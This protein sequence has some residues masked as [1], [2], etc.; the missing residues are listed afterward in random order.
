MREF[1]EGGL[2]MIRRI[3]CPT[4]LTAN[5]Q[6]PVGYALRLAKENGAELIVF[7]AT[8]FPVLSQYTC[9]LDACYPWESFVSMFKMD[10]LLADA[11]RRVRTFV[12]ARFGN[13]SAGVAWKPKVALG[14][15]AEEIVRAAYQEEVD[16][17]VMG[18]C[19]KGR[20]ARLFTGSIPEAVVRSVPCPVLSIDV[21]QF[22]YPSRGWRLPE[23]KGLL[24]NS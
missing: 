9:E 8:S 3:L 6:D 18:R 19:K 4:G 24:Q 15:A 17:V 7:H 1:F 13:E 10:Q 16:L 2:T 20:L 12:G 14:E 23:L 22:I 21:T 5:S 11:E